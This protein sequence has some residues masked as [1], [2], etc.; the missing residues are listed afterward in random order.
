MAAMN[1]PGLV[2]DDANQLVR[3]LGLGDR[4]GIDE[5]V[6]STDDERVER[7]V[8]NQVNLD[9]VA[10]YV[11][12]LEDRASVFR[13]ESLGFR[14]ANE[15]SMGARLPGLNGGES[16]RGERCGRPRKQLGP[17]SQPVPVRQW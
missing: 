10:R 2:G 17:V 7:S 6:L 9:I 11:R 4:A 14:I 13:D 16:E 5:H 15:A 12:R 8:V 1:V 3:R